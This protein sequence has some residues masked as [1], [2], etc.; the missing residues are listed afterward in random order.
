M[1]KFSQSVNSGHNRGIGWLLSRT[2]GNQ[3]KFIGAQVEGR[4]LLAGRVVSRAFETILLLKKMQIHY[5]HERKLDLKHHL[6]RFPVC[7]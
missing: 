5:G 4:R 1:S 2:A 6:P 7:R 3:A